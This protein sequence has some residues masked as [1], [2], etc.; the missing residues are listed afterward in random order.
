M[1]VATPVLVAGGVP[2]L[3]PLIML[4][5]AR[6]PHTAEGSGDGLPRGPAAAARPSLGAP[7]VRHRRNPLCVTDRDQQSFIRSGCRRVHRNG[8][9]K[10]RR[11]IP[12]APHARQ[13]AL[14]DHACCVAGCR[15]AYFRPVRQRRPLRRAARGVSDVP[16]AKSAVSGRLRPGSGAGRPRRAASS[17]RARPRARR[18]RVVTPATRTAVWPAPWCR[19]VCSRV[20]RDCPRPT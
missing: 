15:P 8:Q 10:G 7:R 20:S 4:A 11:P 3:V 2:I 19:A 17:T 1:L 18:Q 16:D 12:S 13:P 6:W 9:S 5:L 14:S